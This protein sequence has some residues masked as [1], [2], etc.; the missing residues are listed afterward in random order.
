M[1]LF[2]QFQHNLLPR[3]TYTTPQFINDMMNTGVGTTLYKA[4]K[5]FYEKNNT[6]LPYKEEEFKGYTARIDDDTFL[7]VMRFPKPEETPLCFASFIF[8]D[9]KTNEKAYYTVEKGKDPF[10]GRDMQFLCTW[11]KNASHRNYGSVCPDEHPLNDIFL[12]R[13]FYARF[14]GLKDVRTPEEPVDGNENTRIYKCPVCGHEIIYDHL[15]I[16][17]GDSFLLICERCAV[18]Y[19]LKYQNGEYLMENNVNKEPAKAES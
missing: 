10:D 3:W 14:R 17:E 12:T 4:A 9:I 5:N 6:E 11:D 19:K 1:N 7:V 16:N 15:N 18:I 8:A 13:Y 2:Y